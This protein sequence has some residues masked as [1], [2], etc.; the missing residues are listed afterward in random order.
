[1]REN[2]VW[3]SKIELF[4]LFHT[5][6]SLIFVP[7]K[8]INMNK[9]KYSK[10]ILL[11]L[12][13]VVFLH[14]VSAQ[15]NTERMLVIG[16]NALYFEDYLLSIQYFNQVISAKPYL[17]EPYFFRG[18]AKFYLEDFQGAEADC[19]LALER[20]PFIV[21]AYEVRGLS[22]LSIGKFKE[23]AADY[24]MGLKYYPEN[25]I[26]LLNKAIALQNDKDYPA[27]R[28][29][30]D[31]LLEKYPKY[32]KAYLGRAQLFLAEKDTISAM[33]D[34]DKCIEANENNVTAYLVRSD[35]KLRTSHDY[36]SALADMNA[37]I[38]LEPKQADFFIN[39][40]YLKYNLDDYFGAMSD[41]DYA[42]G[43]EPANVAAHFNRGLLRMEVQDVNKAIEDFSFVIEQEPD[44]YRA[45][46]NRAMLYQQIQDYG[47][48][49]KDFDKVIEQ[50]P[51]LPSLY[52]ARSE[53]KRLMGDMKGGEQDYNKSRQMQ[54]NHEERRHII[55]ENDEDSDDAQKEETPEEVIKKFTSLVTVENDNAVKPEYDN[56]YRGK[57]QNYDIAVELEGIYIL[58]YYDRTTELRTNAYY[59]KE[60]DEMNSSYFLRDKLYITNV[61]TRLTETEI[62]TQFGLIQHYS[63]LLSGGDK[64]ALDYFG[65]A[66]SYTLVK[67]YD[68]AIADLSSAVE[69]SPRFVLAY[70]ARATA[71]YFKLLSDEA[72]SVGSILE[73]VGIDSAGR[74][75][76]QAELK[77]VL[78][79]LNKV[80]EL[81]PDL[82]YAY[83]NK[84]NI[85][86]HQNDYT[87][88]ISCYTSAI[89]IKSDFGEA[90][91]NRGIAYL[92]LGNLDKGMADLSRAGELG[93]MSSYNVIKRMRRTAN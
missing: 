29:T 8:Q 68:S 60:I 64:K 4:C 37:A 55:A 33:S 34:I 75:L 67:N 22:R 59:Q 93:I 31:V 53:S 77:S 32:D 12:L 92:R 89:D 20:N 24:D 16:K 79:D 42:I 70:F 26:F 51:Y 83:F 65:R 61:E 11:F 62:E 10:R 48:S 44:N 17:A 88:A 91:Y 74:M 25:Q 23:A 72:Q 7:F 66:L 76:A 54:K 36:E 49:I 71:K 78:D 30:F 69:L 52:Y 15:L 56:K 3:R 45:L 35:L 6:L 41:F 39:R 63:S 85:Y 84:G 5:A 19:N 50:F 82:V 47:K 18:L 81:S 86:Y 9:F 73:S 40:A 43:L 87:A 1:M 58:T 27:S 46:Y 90:Y 57:I 14:P 2:A 21:D 38:K 80:I 28:A 13:S